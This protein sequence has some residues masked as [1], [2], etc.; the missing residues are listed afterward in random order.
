M[1][2]SCISS[3]NFEEMC[4]ID[5]ASNNIELF[6]GSDT[7]DIIDKLFDTILQRS[8]EARETSNVRGSKFIHESFGLLYYYFYKI[9]M[10]RGESYIELPEWLKNKKAAINP[11]NKN[12][13]NCFQYV[14]TVAL[15]HQNIGRDLQRISSKI[16]PVINKYN[17][18]GIEF[19]TMQKEQNNKTVALNI[20]YVQYNTKQICSAYKSEYNNVRENIV[21]LLMITDGKKWHYL[22]LKS[23]PIFY[24]GK[25]CNCPIKILS[26]LLRGIT[27][28]HHRDFYCLN[29]YHSRR[30]E[31][32]LKEH[33]EVCN[34]HDSC[35]IEMPKR[36]EKILKYNHGEK[37]LKAP[38]AICLD[39]ECLLPKIPS[40]QNNLKNSY[41]ERKAKHEASGWAIFI[42]CSFDAAKNKLDY[43]RG[44]NCIK[45]LCKLLKDHTMETINHEEK[46][47]IQLT[48][49]ENKSYDEQE[50]CHVYKKR[51]FL[52]END[53]NENDEKIK[54]HQKV[55]VHCYYT[56]KFRGA[57]HSICNLRYKVPKNIPIVIHN[58][59]TYHYHFIINQLAEEFNGEFDCIGENMEKYITFSVPV[60]NII[61]KI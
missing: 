28:N 2:N 58:G 1:L 30:K 6:V 13:D 33:E 25:L 59:S 26:R 50:V 47:M 8:Q 44:R 55:K 36:F 17:W 41:T 18:K 15:S 19:P 40:C 7:D 3:K 23:E 29:C 27:S 21:M 12:D 60:K 38:F 35:P 9:D 16:V 45:K 56:G 37:S 32:R 10:K 57:A 53:E 46:E 31:N 43:Y 54:K 5:L 61:K 34:K 49:E 14:I 39:L 24:G 22:A 42:K 48:D 4:S 51:I 20:L 52:D 11:K